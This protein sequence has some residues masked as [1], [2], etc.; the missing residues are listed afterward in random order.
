MIRK[1]V[2]GAAAS[3]ALL[4]AGSAGAQTPPP[5]DAA[6]G[7]PFCSAKVKDRCIQRSDIRAAKAAAK[8]S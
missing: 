6:S 1:I 3:A 4:F 5:T 8:A 7:L 2:I